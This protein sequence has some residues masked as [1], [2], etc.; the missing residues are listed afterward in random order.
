ME[1]NHAFEQAKLQYE[2]IKS[3]LAE[4]DRTA[5]EEDALEVQ[6]RSA[7]ENPGSADLSKPYEFFILLCTG[8]PAVRIIGELGRYCQPDKA[9]LQYQD[10]GTPWTTYHAAESDVL[11]EY[12]SYF[13][14]GE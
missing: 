10:W 12:A 11:C 1:L 2:S 5:I 8:G 3:L 14:Y 6:V 9:W 13:Y 4:K 7:W